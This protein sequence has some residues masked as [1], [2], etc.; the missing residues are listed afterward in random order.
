MKI[1]RDQIFD[2][3]KN[4]QHISS[5]LTRIKRKIKMTI[6]LGDEASYEVRDAIRFNILTLQNRHWAFS[7][8][9]NVL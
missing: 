2:K 6:G 9:I 8:A 5:P 1:E 4:Q 7:E 3:T